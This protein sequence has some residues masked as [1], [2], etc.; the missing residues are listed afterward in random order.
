MIEDMIVRGL[1]EKTQQL[2]PERP[3]IRGLIGWSPDTAT[4]EDLRLFQLHQMPNLAYNRAGVAEITTSSEQCGFSLA[5]FY[6][7]PRLS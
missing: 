3:G 6:R 4:A 1:S 2:C 7:L 5:R